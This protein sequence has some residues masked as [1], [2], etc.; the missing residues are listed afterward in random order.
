M[1]NLDL[2]KYD[3]SGNLEIVH[4][5]SYEQLF[6]AEIDPAN[7]GFEKGV[8]TTTGAVSVDTGIFTG[9]SPKDKYFVDQEP[10]NKNIAW[11]R[12]NHKVSKEVYEELFAKV[13]TQLSNK[14]IYIQDVYSGGSASSRKS[15]RFVTEIAWQAHFVKNMFI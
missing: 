2:S 15:I 9:R 7:E 5:P 13:K 12:I 11:G 8:V 1:A 14:D 4:N 10:S 6:Q 3:I